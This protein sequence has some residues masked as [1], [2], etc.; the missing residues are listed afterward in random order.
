MIITYGND[1][2]SINVSS[3][4]N[5]V[6]NILLAEMYNSLRWPKILH[7]MYIYIYIYIYTQKM[8]NAVR[9]LFT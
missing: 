1:S 5:T 2:I 9:N 4:K 6:R 7:F 8:S 3:V